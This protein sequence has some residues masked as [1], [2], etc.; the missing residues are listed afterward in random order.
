MVE[1]DVNV[2]LLGPGLQE[3]HLGL[4]DRLRSALHEPR[5]IAQSIHGI[6]GN[7]QVDMVNVAQDRAELLIGLSH[8]VGHGIVGV[9]G[10]VFL[11]A[12]ISAAV[13]AA[14][15]AIVIVEVIGRL[16]LGVLAIAVGQSQ[17][18]GKEAVVRRVGLGDAGRQIF[19]NGNF[20]SEGHLAPV[21]LIEVEHMARI[22]EV[23][24]A[25]QAGPVVAE[26]DLARILLAVERRLDKLEAES[27]AIAG[28]IGVEQVVHRRGI[29]HLPTVERHLVL[30]VLTEGRLLPVTT[31]TQALEPF[32]IVGPLL[33]RI[34]A[35]V[36]QG[37]GAVNVGHRGHAHVVARLVDAVAYRGAQMTHLH[38][39][40]ISVAIKLVVVLPGEFRLVAVGG[41]MIALAVITH[42]GLMGMR[43]A[44]VVA[45]A[46]AHFGLH[47]AAAQTSIDVREA[48]T[49][50]AAVHRHEASCY[51]KG[52]GFDLVPLEPRAKVG[53][54]SHT[55]YHAGL[56]NAQRVHHA[57]HTVGLR[58]RVAKGLAIGVGLIV[59]GRRL[60]VWLT[61]AR[62]VL[63]QKIKT[64]VARRG[65]RRRGI[66][67]IRMGRQILLA[68]RIAGPVPVDHLD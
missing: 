1:A 31:H 67:V 46:H 59:G 68:D 41:V 6:G 36:G 29:G 26:V 13:L 53:I 8:T 12:R 5:R 66:A 14:A 24:V 57:G 30:G 21:A 15:V 18:R 19:V 56:I 40:R 51:F 37:G 9:V 27:T 58:D 52:V 45:A 50:I 34:E 2:L 4:V 64:G 20:I 47:G 22:Q 25:P 61:L 23:L 43:V 54:L 62:S 38:R 28:V 7:M 65:S 3:V 63:V 17:T 16:V 42:D 32:R 10:I 60:E 44:R 48:E 39:H 11:L 33:P 35:R 55:A 49:Q